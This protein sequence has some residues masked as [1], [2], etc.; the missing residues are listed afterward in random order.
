MGMEE[1][2]I[3]MLLAGGEPPP[4]RALSRESSVPLEAWLTERQK[5][6]NS[7]SRDAYIHISFIPAL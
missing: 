1:G 5:T 2:W 7:Y 3:I 6:S 4:W